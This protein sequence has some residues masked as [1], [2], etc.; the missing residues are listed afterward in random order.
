MTTT[1]PP[2]APIQWIALASIVLSAVSPIA[3][4]TG[5]I[6]TDAKTERRV[7]EHDRRIEQLEQQQQPAADKQ[8]Q[9]IDRLA[10]IETKLEMLTPP[11]SAPHP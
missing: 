6:R 9:I 10:R 7:D 4:A 11:R 5:V 1:T 2:R 3:I 8:T